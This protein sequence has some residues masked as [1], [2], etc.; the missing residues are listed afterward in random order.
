MWRLIVAALVTIAVACGGSNS[1]RGRVALVTGASRGIGKGIALALAERGATIYVTGRS[2]NGRSTDDKVGG[3]LD[4]VVCAIERLGGRGTALKCDHTR[5]DQVKAVFDR[6][7]E[8][9]GKL[10][11]LVN[12]AFQVPVRPDGKE[13]PDL[14]FKNFWEQPGWFWDTLIDVGLRSHYVSSVYAVPLLKKA[15]VQSDQDGRTLSPLIVHIS[16]FGGVSYSFNV[17]YGVGKAGV[18][19]MARDMHRELKPLG[20]S[21]VSLYPGVVSTERM[22]GMLGLDRDLDREGVVEDR[23]A[24]AGAGAGAGADPE[25]TEWQRRT[26][27]ASPRNCIET[28][29]LSGRVIAAL[30]ENKDGKLSSRS[31]NVCV[32]AECAKELG[33]VDTT[34]LNPPSIRSLKFLIPAVVLGRVKGL[35]KQQVKALEDFLCKYSPDVLLPMSFM[36]GGAPDA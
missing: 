18:D 20:I 26:G 5:D 24:G 14:L 11:I 35:D 25:I 2:T 15:A 10:D 22:V 21:C 1:L 19:K 34:G 6:I 13:D 31:G 30:Y 3:T 23:D 4:E 27:L 17:A 9:C 12:N 32:T 7:D 28:P 36:S 29:V 16:S 33:V 8:E